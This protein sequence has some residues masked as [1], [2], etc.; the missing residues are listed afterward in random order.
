MKVK[1]KDIIERNLY[2]ERS[3]IPMKDSIFV[4][5]DDEIY[6]ITDAVLIRNV[7]K[8]ED[9]ECYFMY[10]RD[11]FGLNYKGVRMIVPQ[12]SLERAKNVVNEYRKSCADYAEIPEELWNTDKK[13]G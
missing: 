1:P 6:N 3:D 12:E 7:L 9:I 10:V 5:L 4:D 13:A 11:H 8:S 2:L